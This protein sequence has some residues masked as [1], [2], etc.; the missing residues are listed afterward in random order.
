MFYRQPVS[1]LSAAELD[2][3]RQTIAKSKA[4]S[5]NR[6]FIHFAGMHGWPA[7]L[8][9]H[10]SPLFLPWHRA[11]LYMFEMSLR[12]ITPDVSLPWWDWTS[13]LSHQNGIPAAYTDPA[14]NP[15]LGSQTGLDTDTLSQIQQ[16]IPD[17]LDFTVNPPQT[18]RAPGSPDQL[19]SADTIESVL[20]EGTFDGFTNRL[21]DQHNQVHGWTGGSM[22]IV[23]LAAY[24]PVFWAHHCMID[25]LW[26]L[27]QLRNPNGG[28]GSVPLNQALEGFPLTVAQTLDINKLGYEYATKVNVA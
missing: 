20:Q 4:L 15:L 8:C 27:W 7:N 18:V 12:D 24:D 16:Q 9:Q 25:R 22:G 14:P 10:G 26:Y 21:E 2:T 23:P 13:G 17:A 28:V 3:F 1:N 11:Y 19:P 6:G 5:D